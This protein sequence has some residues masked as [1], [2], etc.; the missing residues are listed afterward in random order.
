M[1]VVVVVV[2]VSDPLGVADAAHRER[3]GEEGQTRPRA[4]QVLARVPV[5]PLLRA[6]TLRLAVR[7]KLEAIS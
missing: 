6:W 4:R 7:L 2:V 5:R 3:Q 1:V